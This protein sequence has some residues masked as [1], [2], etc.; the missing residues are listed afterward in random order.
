M[1]AKAR[2]GIYPAD[3]LN[4]LPPHWRH[5]YFQKL[6]D[7]RYQ[8]V[9]RIRKEVVYRIFNLMDPIVQKKPFDIIFCRNVMIYFDAE[10]TRR[11]VDRLYQATAVGGYLFIGHSESIDKNQTQYTYRCPA[12]YQKLPKGGR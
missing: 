11:L 10:T 12:V 1:L 5:Q 3:N 9:D 2:E 4:G 7:G 8:V 6:P